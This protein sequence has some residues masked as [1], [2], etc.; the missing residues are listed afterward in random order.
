ML[1]SCT[2]SLSTSVS[3][4][5]LSIP[6]DLDGVFGVDNSTITNQSVKL[7][8][9]STETEI[10]ATVNG[11]GGGDVISLTPN[12]PLEINTVYRFEV[13]GVKDL[14]GVAFAP[15]SSTFTTAADNTGSGNALDNVSFTN[16]GSVATD[17]MYTSLEVG[18]DG[19][20]YGL[21]ISG[22]VDRWVIDPDG[23]LSSQ[24]TITTL[25]D[26][27]GIRAAI[28]F[29]FAPSSNAG[30]L[31]AYVSH[32]EGVL[33]NGQPWDGKISQLSGPNLENYALVVT[34]LPRSRRDHLVNSITFNPPILDYGAKIYCIM[35][36]F[37]IN[38]IDF[39]LFI[40]LLCPDYVRAYFSGQ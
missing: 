19:K 13:D 38:V 16:G 25:V 18:P 2:V 7:F 36:T 5:E 37:K 17:G 28:G 15:F 12:F 32:S 34:N 3:A 10:P 8:K 22:E 30:N 31:V 40:T 9:V 4:N 24:E 20:L 23:R 21:K 6:N 39:I 14:T 11:S 35:L 33:N 27:A 26:S 1:S 29:A